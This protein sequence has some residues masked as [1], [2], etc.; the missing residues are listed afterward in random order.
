MSSIWDSYGVEFETTAHQILVGT[1]TDLVNYIIPNSCT[2]IKSGNTG[3]K[4]SFYSCRNSLKTISAQEGSNLETIDAYAFQ[5]MQVLETVDFSKCKKLLIINDWLFSYTESLINLKLPPMLERIEN[6]G[7]AMCKKLIT[8]ELPSTV[9]YIGYQAFTW[10]KSLTK[11]N[12]PEDSQLVTIYSEA[13][14]IGALKEFFI[15]QYVTSF[16]SST[17]GGLSIKITIHP[18]NTN[19]YQTSDSVLTANKSVLL[20]TNATG[21]YKVPETVTQMAVNCLRWTAIETIKMPQKIESYG[22]RWFAQSTI[23]QITIPP[24][25]T[26]LPRF[27][28][29]KCLNLTSV[30]LSDSITTIE[31]HCFTT[32]K[33][34]E[35][36]EL[37]QITTI[38]DWAFQDCSKLG[39]ISLPSTLTTFGQGVFSGC[40]NIDINSTQNSNFEVKDGMLFSQG[41]T[42]L[43]EFFGNQ[44]NIDIPYFC[45]TI[46]NG[47]FR[48]KN[49]KKVTFQ[50]RI[51]AINIG[52]QSFDSSQIESISF[53][54][55]LKS[56][57]K[58]CF[59]NCYK[60]KSVTFPENCQITNIP[61]EA[62]YNCSILSSVTLPFNVQS[63]GEKSFS[64]C[65]RLNSINLN[66]TCVTSI[67]INSFSET[68]LTSIEFPTTLQNLSQFSFARCS[69]LEVANL[70]LTNI[71]IL[72]NYC[73]TYCSGLQTIVFPPCL[74]DIEAE[75]FSYCSSLQ[76]VNLPEDIQYIRSMAF[77]E[78]KSLQKV[79]LPKDS[80]LQIIYGKA[81]G[82]CPNL[83]N[84]TI[85]PE[86]SNFR[87]ENGVLLNKNKTKLVMY[88]PSSTI[89]TYVV[90]A[91]VE[92]IG[93][94]SFEDCTNLKAL[95][96]AD[97]NVKDIGYSAFKGCINLQYINLPDSLLLGE[98]GNSAFDGC[99]KLECGSIVCS[100]ELQQK[101]K[102]NSEFVKDYMFA[103]SCTKQPIT[104]C[105]C[106]LY[107][108]HYLLSYVFISIINL[109]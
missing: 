53:P 19:F 74:T 105:N 64:C 28:F 72:P 23:T 73:F 36:I 79:V 56:I 43:L 22:Q 97:G 47:V 49:I 90:P 27:S 3:S 89:T 80:D 8:F 38:E 51:N 70:S 42:K 13:F 7:F 33:Q 71:F 11:I 101:I 59:S 93:P 4:S 48:G 17:F 61:N 102:E 63:I 14:A 9:T 20:Y 24:T 104:Q 16:D 30:I 65:P 96:I 50:S 57:G 99:S 41:K 25:A 34:L 76:E 15:P 31:D 39:S 10:T 95:I 18:N 87:F 81:F 94:N 98:I 35:T 6:Y 55:T 88:M 29:D 77:Y 62:F 5:S 52:M 86:D 100:Q 84:I 54:N 44:G 40:S 2:R 67:S 46:G 37:K 106:N 12:I 45:N 91:K 82:R 85:D 60:L 66:E 92:L 58:E 69:S 1:P 107:Q 68:G 83:P 26:I 32:C 109:K 21:H 75:A 78:C 108:Y 103:N